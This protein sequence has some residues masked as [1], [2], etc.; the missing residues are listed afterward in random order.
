MRLSSRQIAFK[1][2]FS[3]SFCGEKRGSR[4]PA[5]YPVAQERYLGNNSGLPLPRLVKLSNAA[6]GC[7]LNASFTNKR[8]IISIDKY[9]DVSR[10]QNQVIMSLRSIIFTYDVHIEVVER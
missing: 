7:C 8:I 3:L 9:K 2:G 6:S 1:I 4:C 10:R 5:Q